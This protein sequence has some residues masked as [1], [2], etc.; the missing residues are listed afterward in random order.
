MNGEGILGLRAVL[1]LGY[2]HRR[3]R[4]SGDGVEEE[5]PEVFG[6]SLGS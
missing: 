6:L 4:N 2:D 1:S 5:L 3:Q